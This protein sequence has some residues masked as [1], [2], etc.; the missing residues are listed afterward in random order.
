MESGLADRGHMSNASKASS[1]AVPS[2]ESL[3]FCR[4]LFK[5][6]LVLSAY[7]FRCISNRPSLASS[8]FK[9]LKKS[10]G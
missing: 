10:P 1:R 5:A 3:G 9:S 4:A 7:S 2:R 8:F 6:Q